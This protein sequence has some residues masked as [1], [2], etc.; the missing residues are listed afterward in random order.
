MWYACGMHG[1]RARHARPAIA[2]IAIVLALIVPPPI[3]AEH[4]DVYLMG[5]QSNM[6]GHGYWDNAHALWTPGSGDVGIVELG[7]MQYADPQANAKFWMRRGANP[8]PI[9][10]RPVAWNYRTD[11]FIA[12]RAGYDLFGY[13]TANPSQL[14]TILEKHPFGAE[15]TF[16]LRM[17]ELRP[18]NKIAIVKYTE[19]GTSLAVD[20]NY[21]AGRTYDPAT[22]SADAGHSYYGFVDAVGDAL[23]ELSAGGD[24][25]TVQG[26]LWH[27][28]E[29]D[30][31]DSTATYANKLT[32]FFGALRDDLDLPQ[33]P[34]AIGELIQ[35][36]TS[37]NNVRAAQL[38]VANAD[39]LAVFVSSLGLT[40]DSS[41]NHFDTVS[42]LAFGTRYADQ[43][44]TIVPEPAF[45]PAVAAVAFLMSRRRSR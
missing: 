4:Y 19:G 37:Y 13:N 26:M 12:N 22:M 17:S 45:A 36:R 20:W 3:R 38:Q 43:L 27:Q 7:L 14:G 6:Q 35:P 28:G 34:I 18:A 15:I 9:G 41:G 2:L 40:G 8:N 21:V 39:P 29:S 31:A 24:T 5:G 11:G 10:G 33:L 32:N 23:A 42:Q 16:G 25:Y 1:D 30:S 44:V